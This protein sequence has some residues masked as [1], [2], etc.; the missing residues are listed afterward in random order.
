MNV[1][2]ISKRLLTLKEAATYLGISPRQ[3]EYLKQYGQVK[4]T[5][6]PNT[7]KRL[8]DVADLDQLIESVKLKNT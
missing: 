8:Y 6:L 7:K 3:L 1:G 5:Y 2:I 4:Q